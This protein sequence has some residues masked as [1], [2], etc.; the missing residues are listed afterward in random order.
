MLQ[1]NQSECEMCHP[2]IEYTCQEHREKNQCPGCN[3]TDQKLIM[4]RMG[5]V[6]RD[7]Y[8]KNGGLF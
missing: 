6:C 1:N 2:E 3:R 4:T 7:C 5:F 8:H